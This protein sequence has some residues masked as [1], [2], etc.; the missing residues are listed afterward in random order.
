MCRANKIYLLAYCILSK[1][2]ITH[3][4]TKVFFA[5]FNILLFTDN[6]MKWN[7][8]FVAEPLNIFGNIIILF[9]ELV[10]DMHCNEIKAFLL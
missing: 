1:S 7:L 5:A 8:F 3:I 10:I 4:P 2:F 6:S 9:N